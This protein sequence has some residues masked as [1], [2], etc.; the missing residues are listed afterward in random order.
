MTSWP[1]PTPHGAYLLRAAR[2]RE[3]RKP[4]NLSAAL[5][6]LYAGE[7]GGSERRRA[8]RLIGPESLR[9]GSRLERNFRD[10]RLLT[11]GE[12]NHTIC[13][14]SSC[15]NCLIDNAVSRKRF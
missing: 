14:T 6:K 12:L 3:E 9:V 4:G 7:K 10:T 11:I 5:A 13:A 1:T 15:V 2:D 8:M